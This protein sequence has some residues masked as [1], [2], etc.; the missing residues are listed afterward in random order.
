L[1]AFGV[2]L[3]D[4]WET[5]KTLSSA[6]TTSFLDDIYLRAKK[7]G[8]LGGKLLGAG[9]GG[10]FIFYVNKETQEQVRKS[11]SELIEVKFNFENDGTKII[12]YT[13]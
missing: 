3:D 1:D 12:F 13:N 11:L 4:A 7:A 5:K 9:G 10:F 6:I 2:L 8:A